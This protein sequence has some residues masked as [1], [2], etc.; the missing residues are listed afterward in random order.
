MI[1]LISR[2]QMTQIFDNPRLENLQR[3]LSSAAQKTGVSF[4]FL[5][6]TAA[7]ESGMQA[8]AKAK[9]SSAAGLFQ[10]VEQ[11]WLG[12]VS[13]YGAKHGLANESVQIQQS[14]NGRFNITDTASRNR[15]LG[16][17]YDPVASAAMAAELTAENRNSLQAK[18]GREP[19]E[20][21]LYVAHFMGAGKAADLVLAAET[22]P[23]KSAAGLFA[24][25]AAAN[26]N[27]FY[28]PSGSAKTVKEVLSELGRLHQ[29][30]AK[31][32][33]PSGPLPTGKT[34]QVEP[35]DSLA[36]LPGG[37]VRSPLLRL[38][39]VLVQLLAELSAPAAPQEF[40][41]K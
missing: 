34:T 19:S 24:K 32:T 40:D 17:R 35:F 26:K 31:I 2:W 16:L 23:Q 39:P 36:K 20:T 41:K 4:D 12:M 25:E 6:K 38:S 37:W 18:L 7:R 28:K 27:I 30:P 15:I 21:E 3:A 8:S 22:T 1:P 10:F 9:T 5:V 13:R 14:S 29:K 33:E 11:T